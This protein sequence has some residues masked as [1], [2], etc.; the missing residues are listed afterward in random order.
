MFC[1]LGLPSKFDRSASIVP[2]FLIRFLGR[3]KRLLVAISSVFH[4][5]ALRDGDPV[6][7]ALIETTEFVTI[8]LLI[9]RY[10]YAIL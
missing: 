8:N 6:W 10:T 4:A 1:L 7:A 2:K 3:I 5:A 9:K